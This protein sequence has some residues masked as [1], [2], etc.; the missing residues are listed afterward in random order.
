LQTVPDIIAEVDSNKVYTWANNAAFRFFGRD[1]IGREASFYF[2][3]DQETYE[4]V[5][6][7]FEGDADI[8]YLESWQRRLDGQKRLLAWWCRALKDATGQVT[9]ALS[10]ARDITEQWHFEQMQAARLRLMEFSASHTLPELLQATLDECELLTGSQAG[11]YHFVEPD[12]TSLSL[13]AWSTNTVRHLCK[14]VGAGL[15]YPVN[16][17]GVWVDCIRQRKAVIHNDYASLSHKKGLPEGH[18][19]VVRELI[20]PVIRNGLIMAVLGVGNKPTDYTLQDQ[21]N[22]TLMAD[23][24]WDISERK[25]SQ[26]ALRESEIK[27]REL[28]ASKDK[29]FSIIAHD[30]KSPFNSILGFSELL[31]SEADHLDVPDIRMYASMISKSAGQTLQLLDNLLT[32]AR[33]QQGKIDFSPGNLLL[34]VIARGMINL[35]RDAAVQKNIVFKC[36]IPDSTVVNADQNMLSTILRNLLSNAVKFTIPGGLVEVSAHE[37]PEA[38]VVMVSDTGVGIPEATLPLLFDPGACITTRGTNNERGTGL[39]LALCREFVE[40][41]GGVISVESTIGKGSRFMFTLPKHK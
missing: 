32:W 15:H 39:G 16:Q 11:F 36:V 5:R 38:T 26:E 33:M 4:K 13:Q 2:E 12:Q 35:I 20:V 14:A 25:R 24:A 7:L 3:G 10:T 1:M 18:A 31:Q 9:G 23:L 37:T 29:F 6:P 27:L 34:A 30:L 17:A 19:P 41:H 40:K 21:Q 8:F 28:N 22:I